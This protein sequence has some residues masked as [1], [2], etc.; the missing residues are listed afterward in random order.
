[1]LPIQELPSSVLTLLRAI[2]MC[3]AVLATVL[4][5]YFVLETEEKPLSAGVWNGD[6]SIER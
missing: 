2:T 4:I 3:H 5:A 1:M 6:E